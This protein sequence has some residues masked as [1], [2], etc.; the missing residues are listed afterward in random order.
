M[1]IHELASVVQADRERAVRSALC[2]RLH[3]AHPA[4]GRPA[5][6]LARLGAWLRPARRPVP[7]TALPRVDRRPT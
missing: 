6:L 7:R 3:L 5:G 4:A 2:R 1:L